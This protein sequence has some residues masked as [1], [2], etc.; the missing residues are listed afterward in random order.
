MDQIRRYVWV[1]A[2]EFFEDMKSGQGTIHFTNGQK[3]EGNFRDDALEGRGK[4][5][6]SDGTTVEGKW[7]GNVLIG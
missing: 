4:F 6:R 5:F 7:S 1:Y 3:V 2:G